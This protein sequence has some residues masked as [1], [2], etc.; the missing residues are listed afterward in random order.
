MMLAMENSRV[1]LELRELIEN[2]VDLWAFD[3]PS[4]YKGDD[5]T[6]FESK[7]TEHFLFRQI[8][9]ETPA[10][11]LHYFRRTM[12][13]IMP[14]YIQRYESVELMKDPDIKPLDNYNMV[15]TY[16]G[17]TSED[18]R[19]TSETATSSTLHNTSTGKASNTRTES[20]DKTSAENDTPQGSLPWSVTN[21]GALSLG[22][23]SNVGQEKTNGSASDTSESS[24]TSTGSDSSETSGTG[25][26]KKT[27]TEG[28]TLTRR[29]NI[30][31]TTYAQL[32]TGYRET[33]LNIDMEIINELEKCFLGVY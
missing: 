30:G 18:N 19:Q 31:V 12:R 23:A 29:G 5:K 21:T 11:F 17:T 7:V 27:G 33:F 28:H 14:Y 2:G 10:R 4:F 25:T 13:E 15:E 6:A 20:G 24:E 9:A 32:L 3:Y 22:H 1:T 8:G 26:E 16:E